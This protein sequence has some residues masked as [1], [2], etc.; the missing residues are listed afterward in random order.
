MNGDYTKIPIQFDPIVQRMQGTTVHGHL[1][2]DVPFISHIQGNLYLGG[3]T[4]GLVLPDYIRNVISLYPWERYQVLGELDSEFYIKAYD[5]GVEKIEPLLAKVSDWAV[6]CL[7]QGKTLIHCQAGLNRSSLIAALALIK[8]G[9]GTPR[10]VIDLVRAKRSP[11]V[12]CNKEFEAW[13][14]QRACAA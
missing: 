13:L 12:L 8:M 10:E 5:A 7:K 2:F 9:V 4:S 6:T 3:C 11:A 1:D 14:L